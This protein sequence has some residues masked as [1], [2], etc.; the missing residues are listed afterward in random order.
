MA[1]LRD[2]CSSSGNTRVTARPRCV[3]MYDARASHVTLDARGMSFQFPAADNLLRRLRSG[4][5]AEVVPHVTTLSLAPPEGKD[6][7]PRT[8][9]MR[10][11]AS[12]QICGR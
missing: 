12:G 6:A 7:A 2:R 10:Y 4:N 11:A 3:K 1:E 9:S 5:L 8:L